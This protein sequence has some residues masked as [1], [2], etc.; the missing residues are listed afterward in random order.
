MG[1]SGFSR[2][3]AASNGSQGT[4]DLQKRH[5][6]G[7]TT[8][9]GVAQLGLSIPPHTV[10]KTPCRLSEMLLGLK[11]V[12][13]ILPSRAVHAAQASLDTSTIAARALHTTARARRCAAR[14]SPAL[15]QTSGGRRLQRSSQCSLYSGEALD[16]L[17]CTSH[18]S[19]GNHQHAFSS[20]D[21]YLAGQDSLLAANGL[22]QKTSQQQS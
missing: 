19:R 2:T 13:R 11:H 8:A 15:G 1:G 4:D 10:H 7:S 21:Q 3:T 20:L 9:T 17:A 22:S 14:I 6:N 5:F 12:L 16:V 18:P